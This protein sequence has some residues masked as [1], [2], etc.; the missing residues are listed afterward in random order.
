MTPTSRDRPPTRRIPELTLAVLVGVYLAVSIVAYTDH[1]RHGSD[2]PLTDLERRGLGVWRSHDCQACHQLY[3]FGGFLG[4]DLTNRVTDGTPDAELRS[5]LEEG[6]RAMPAFH[7]SPAER[8]AVLAFLRA[9]DRTG[10][11]QPTPVAARR[12]VNP[13]EQLERLAGAW[14]E[15]GAPDLTRGERHGLQA[16]SRFGCGACH[17]PFTLGRLRAPDLSRA[18]VDRSVSGLRRVLRHGRR[19]MPPYPRA[20]EQAEE[21]SAFLTWVSLNRAELRAL[22]DRMLEREAFSWSAVPWWEYR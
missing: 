19:N 16:W 11:S 9:V 2:P 18:A 15:S 4:P 22:N 20:A 14:L 21:L 10:Q 7:L 12:R 6:A 1:P 8:R 3:G 17:T 13:T 5:I